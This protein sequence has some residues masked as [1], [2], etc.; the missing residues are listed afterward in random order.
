MTE[1]LK[2][3]WKR[4]RPPRPETEKQSER[5]IAYVTPEEAKGIRADA[6][7]LGLTPSAFLADLWRQWR[8]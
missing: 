1:N 5:V 6:E 3:T 2:K 8:A 7:R 4:G